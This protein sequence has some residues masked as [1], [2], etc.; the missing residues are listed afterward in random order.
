VVQVLLRSNH[1]K[2]P[3]IANAF[4]LLPSG[5]YS[6]LFWSKLHYTTVSFLSL[7]RA[8]NSCLRVANGDENINMSEDESEGTG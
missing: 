8:A 5:T 7:T 3:P 4:V 6:S 1:L 2:P